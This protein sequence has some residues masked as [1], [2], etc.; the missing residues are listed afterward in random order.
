M[1]YAWNPR[2]QNPQN[3][4]SKTKFKII[5]LVAPTPECNGGLQSRFK[6]I[7]LAD[8]IPAY[9]QFFRLELL[10]GNFNFWY[11]FYI[12]GIEPLPFSV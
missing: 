5:I 8:P 1:D 12:C 9:R 10:F 7:I 11:F 4:I 6:K 2:F 3:K